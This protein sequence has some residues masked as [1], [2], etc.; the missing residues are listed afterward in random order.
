MWTAIISGV[1]A[2][3]GV[4]ITAFYANK[5]KRMMRIQMDCRLIKLIQ[6]AHKEL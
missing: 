6:V 2:L 3:I 5:K 4:I 1:L